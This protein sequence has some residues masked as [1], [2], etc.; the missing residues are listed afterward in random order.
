MSKTDP[1]HSRI[2]QEK[3][4]QLIAVDHGLCAIKD[5][6]GRYVD[7]TTKAVGLIT[8]TEFGSRKQIR[9][10]FEHE[11]LSDDEVVRLYYSHDNLAISNDAWIGLEPCCWE[12]VSNQISISTKY[13]IE[14]KKGEVIGCFFRA[15]VLENKMISHHLQALKVNQLNLNSKKHASFQVE[16]NPH[17][18]LHTLTSREAACLFYTIHGKTAKGIV[19]LLGVSSKTVEY[20]IA[21]LKSI[22]KCQS[23]SELIAKAIEQGFLQKM[24]ASILGLS[25]ICLY[26]ER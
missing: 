19:R 1:L 24:P 8:N 2:T 22:F 6:Q 9:G 7:L 18:S 21:N 14:N 25:D 20:Y 3:A 23:K 4:E 17:D 16:F 12:G 26:S 15:I 13:A 5:L 11:L 10:R